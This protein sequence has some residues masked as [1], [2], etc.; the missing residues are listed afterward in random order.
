V[1]SFTRRNF[2]SRNF[3]WI[4]FL[5][6]SLLAPRFVCA[7]SPAPS[8]DPIYQLFDD[9]SDR[10]VINPMPLELDPLSLG[11]DASFEERMKRFLNP[12]LIEKKLAGLAD[13]LSSED[14]AGL[15]PSV[16]VTSYELKEKE[17]LTI[18]IPSDEIFEKDGAPVL[19]KKGQSLLAGVGEVIARTPLRMIW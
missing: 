16:D 4:F 11:F 8:A 13:P 18:Q 2:T 1:K 17:N 10:M 7:S 3:I 19:T 9:E 6:L 14:G 5:G 12:P 15:L